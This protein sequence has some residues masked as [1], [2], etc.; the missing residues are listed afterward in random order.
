MFYID[1]SR[2]VFRLW[3]NHIKIYEWLIQ[4]KNISTMIKTNDILTFYAYLYIN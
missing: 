2:Y 3:I 1:P 4:Y